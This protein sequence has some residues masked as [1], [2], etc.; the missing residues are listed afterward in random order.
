ML[1]GQEP[2]QARFSQAAR[3]RGAGVTLQE[4]E[5]DPAVQIPEQ[6]QRTRPEPRK[7]RAQLVGQRGPR[8]D[9]ILSCSGQ[10]PERLR[11]VAVRLQDPEAVVTGARQLAQHERVKPIG[12]PAR[13]AKAIAGGRDLVGVQR[14]D[15][16]S[17]VQQ[18]LDQQPV[19]PLDRDQLH[20]QAHQRPAQGPQ[21]LLIVRERRR[22]QPLARRVRDEH[23]VLLRRPV[24]AGV[25][26]I[27]L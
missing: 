9:E 17:C 16:Q 13:G 7:L 23:I 24:N 20:L 3:V 11:L 5:R 8:A 4:R 21:T 6:A 27:H 14:Q 15:P 22:Q 18:P 19:G 26:S 10:R 2:V 1:P 12:L 25:T